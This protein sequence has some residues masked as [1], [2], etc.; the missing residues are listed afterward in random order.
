[1]EDIVVFIDHEQGVRERLQEQ[2]YRSHAVLTLSEIKTTL[3]RAG[4]IDEAQFNLL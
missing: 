2:G 1:V 4:R 3:F